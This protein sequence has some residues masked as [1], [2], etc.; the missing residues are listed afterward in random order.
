VT[1]VAEATTLP[2]ELIRDPKTDTP[3]PLRARSFVH[4]HPQAAQVPTIPEMDAGPIR[5]LLVICRPGGRDDVPFRSVASHLVKGLSEDTR[6]LLQLDVLRPPTFEQL[7]R[8]LRRAKANGKPYHIVHFDG[9]GGYV[10]AAQSGSHSRL[11]FENPVAG[12]NRQLVD[13]TALGKLLAETGVPVLVLNACRSAYANPPPAPVAAES[14]G[15]DPHTQVRAFGSLAQEVMD[16]GAV[17]VVAMRYNVYVATAAQF[18]A[19]LYAELIMGRTLGEAVTFCRKQLADNPLRDIAYEPRRL[20]DWSVPV[21]YEAAP[22]SIFPAHDTSDVLTID[23]N[24]DQGAPSRANLDPKLPKI[25]DAG[26]FGRDETLLALDRAFDTQKIVLLHAYA[27]SGKTAT[28]AEFARWYALTGGVLGP[29]LFTSFEQYQPLARVLDRIGDTFGSVLEPT[30]VHWLALDDELRRN[31]TMQVL[32]QIPVLWVW[33]N[34]E[35]VTGFPVGT[36]SAW[37]KEEQEELSDFL[38]DCKKTKA[39]FLLTSRRDER[40][41]LGENLPARITIPPM[42]MWERLQ[43]ARAIAEK[44]GRRLADVESWLPLLD[45]TQGNPLTLTVVVGQALRDGLE[46]RGEIKDFVERLRA[47]EAAFDDEMSEGRSKS[48]GASLSYA[49]DHAF[50]ENERRQLALLHF[51][52]GFVDVGT[53]RLMGGPEF[54]WCLP[55]VRGMTREAAI[56]LLDRATEIGLLTAISGGCYTIHPVLPWFFKSLFDKYYAPIGGCEQEMRATRAFVEAMGDLGNY[57]HLQYHAGYRD[58]IAALTAEE[59]NMLHARKLARKHGWYRVIGTMQGLHTLYTNTGRRAEWT[60][61]VDEIVPDFVDMETDGPLPGREEKW[62]IITEYRV[63]LARE[64]RDLAKAERLQRT[65]LDWDRKRAASSLAVPPDMLD[66]DQRHAIQTLASSL[67]G[68]GDIQRELKQAECVELYEESLTLRERLGGRVG[69]NTC[70]FNIGNAYMDIPTLRDLNQ[71]EQWYQRSLELHDAHDRPGQARCLVQLGVV[72]FERSIEAVTAKELLQHT[73]NALHRY[74]QALDMLP[75]DAVGDLAVL[76]DQLG[77]I[78]VISDFD[79]AS[80]HYREAIRYAEMQDNIYGAAITRHKFALALA[81]AGRFA[82]ALDYARAALHNFERYSDGTA[83]EIQR[84][85]ES[86]TL[87]EQAQQD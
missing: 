66:D 39:K 55:E 84:T 61:L 49:F 14:N 80:L 32:K 40:A 68:L 43:L 78:L 36:E 26:F 5:I 18:V 22:I 62:S 76:H 2:W 56:T 37:N 25:P 34:V 81:S 51:F 24:E 83:D 47:G 67:E 8:I 21:V 77:T 42:P 31:V 46:T 79:R 30:G 74:Q 44:H 54:D 71:A 53:L 3:L 29:V 65:C 41:W 10:N 1:T 20:Q 57:R 28:A 85:R 35:P 11:L 17:G 4:A 45:F 60:R 19:D 33:D 7:G 73:N 69:A 59:A 52:Q 23:L 48:L 50:S 9:H 87:I 86:I 82:D 72:A 64:A 16:A 13:G 12:D 6:T 63:R 38:R 15:D 27:G 58:V 75:P 70:A